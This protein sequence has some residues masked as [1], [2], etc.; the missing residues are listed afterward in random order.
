MSNRDLEIG[1]KSFGSKRKRE[2]HLGKIGNEC[3][4]SLRSHQG[5]IQTEREWEWMMPLLSVHT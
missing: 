4:G 3:F 2:G 5:L 1:Q